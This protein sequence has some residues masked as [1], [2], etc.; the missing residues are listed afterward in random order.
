[1]IKLGRYNSGTQT[2]GIDVNAAGITINGTA[3]ALGGTV[4]IQARLG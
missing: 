3:V 1:M 4:T 2:V